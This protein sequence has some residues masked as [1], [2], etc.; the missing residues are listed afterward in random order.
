[1]GDYDL[2]GFKN[3][4]DDVKQT[5]VV[6]SATS[7]VSERQLH[8]ILIDDRLAKRIE[9]IDAALSA[10]TDRVLGFSDELIDAFSYLC[11]AAA[12]DVRSHLV[13]SASVQAIYINPTSPLGREW[14]SSPPLPSNP[15][16]PLR[17]RVYHCSL[18]I[19]TPS[20]RRPGANPKP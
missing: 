19:N 16:L 4:T 11:G 5:I 15:L 10:E 3:L 12:H 17:G 1:M 9:C 8:V 14:F 2:K 18:L 13:Q 7:M 20:P 6:V